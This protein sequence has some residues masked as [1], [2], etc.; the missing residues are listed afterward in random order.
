MDIPA[1]PCETGS[2]CWR[3]DKFRQ[4]G[5][6]VKAQRWGRGEVREAPCWGMAGKPGAQESRPLSE[7][8]ELFLHVGSSHEEEGALRYLEARGDLRT[9][10]YAV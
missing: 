10:D 2:I 6:C 3:R 9:R 5:A 8:A 4:E 1:G 7:V